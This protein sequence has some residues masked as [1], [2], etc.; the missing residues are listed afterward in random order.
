MLLA[1]E[2]FDKPHPSSGVSKRPWML[3]FVRPIS[4]GDLNGLYLTGQQ[5]TG[6]DL[7]QIALDCW[8]Y[9][10]NA[11]SLRSSNMTKSFKTAG[12]SLIF[13]QKPCAPFGSRHDSWVNRKFGMNFGRRVFELIFG[14]FIDLY[15]NGQQIN[16]ILPPQIIF[17]RWMYCM[18]LI[19]LY[20]SN[21]MVSFRTAGHCLIVLHTPSAPFGS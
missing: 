12:H 3:L 11:L 7:L 4:C 19:S 2:A 14:C 15:L 10:M 6:F 16:R 20:S 1:C 8:I 13:R 21:V 18:S 5:I 17:D 9:C